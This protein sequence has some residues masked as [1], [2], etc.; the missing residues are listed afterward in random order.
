MDAVV[1]W[2]DARERLP[3]PGSPVAAAIAGRYPDGEDFWLVRPMHFT[4]R[5]IAEDGTQRRDCFVDSDGVVRPPYGRP[6]DEP[7][8]H[9]AYLPAL[10]GRAAHGLL[11]DDARTA[12]R[13]ILG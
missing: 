8:T 2:V 7:V 9:W 11:G 3:E 4:D 12:L 13:N 1:E 6:G 5:H 10:P